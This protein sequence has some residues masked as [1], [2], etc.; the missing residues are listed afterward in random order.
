M[1][2]LLASAFL[3]FMPALPG[4]NSFPAAHAQAAVSE[5]NVQLQTS[6]ETARRRAAGFLRSRSLQSRTAPAQDSPAVALTKARAQHLALAAGQTVS[7]NTP[8]TAV[9]PLQVQTAAYGLVTGRITSVAIDPND[10][11]GNTVCKITS[12][13]SDLSATGT[14]SLTVLT[15]TTTNKRIPLAAAMLLLLTPLWLLRRRK[16]P[17]VLAALFAACVCVAMSACGTARTA[18]DAGTGTTSGG[19]SN[20]ITPIGNYNIVASATAAGVTHSVSLT[21][22]V[23]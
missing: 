17:A 6:A 8:W 14:V 9:G 10:P 2:R 23:K 1:S 18:A 19:G 4:G 15:G 11:S 12:Q 7:L 20:T 22:V 3:L 5:A 21:L 13:Y 16:L